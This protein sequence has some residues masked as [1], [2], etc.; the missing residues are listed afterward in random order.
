MQKIMQ[1]ISVKLQIR[2][3]EMKDADQ[4]AEQDVKPALPQREDAF[5]KTEE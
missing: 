3:K 4:E 2:D 5:F 1:T